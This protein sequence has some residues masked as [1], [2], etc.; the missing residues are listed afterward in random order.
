MP[1]KSLS[2]LPVLCC[3][4]GREMAS[5]FPN[6]ARQESQPEI[7]EQQE[8]RTGRLAL[9]MFALAIATTLRGTACQPHDLQAE[10]FRT[11]KPHKI[12]ESIELETRTLSQ[13]QAMQSLFGH[14]DEKR[15]RSVWI[16]APMKRDP[17][18]LDFRSPNRSQHVE[19]TIV[20]TDVEEKGKVAFLLSTLPEGDSYECR[21]CAPLISVAHFRQEGKL[22]KLK[23]HSFL[24]PMGSYATPPAVNLIEIGK[25]TRAFELTTSDLAQGISTTIVHWVAPIPKEDGY[26]IIL[27]YISSQAN[28]GQCEPPDFPCEHTSRKLEIIPSKKDYYDLQ[29]ITR[30]SSTA[31]SESRTKKQ[32]YFFDGKKYRATVE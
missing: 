18:R 15:N 17:D 7:A 14:W 16:M 4:A 5:Q 1:G 13:G 23:D 30:E 29:I 21:I 32:R 10:P 31:H 6:K 25:G 11:P 22:W 19:T 2:I 20:A 27:D 12:P 28:D 24:R 3:H 26:R 8:S 9:L